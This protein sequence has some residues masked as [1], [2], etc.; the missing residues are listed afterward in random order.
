MI[1]GEAWGEGWVGLWFAVSPD[2]GGFGQS[3][4]EAIGIEYGLVLEHEVDGPGQ[5]DGHH[6]VDFEFVAVHAGFELLVE[7]PEA[8]MVAFGDDGGF[9]E[10]PAQVGIAELGSAQALDF[11]GAGDGAA[12]QAAIREEV[13]DGGKRWISPISWRMVRPRFSPMPGTVCKRA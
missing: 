8:V 7:R 12:D 11:A 9:A 3:R 2:S 5:F 10:S 13:F 6:G 4:D 1:F